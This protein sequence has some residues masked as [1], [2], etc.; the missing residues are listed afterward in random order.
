MDMLVLCLFDFPLVL[1]YTVQ[2]IYLHR[3]TKDKAL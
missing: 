2:D 1:R 3:I